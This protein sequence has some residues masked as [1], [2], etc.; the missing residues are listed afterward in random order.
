M[1]IIIITIVV[2][3]SHFYI[4]RFAKQLHMYLI[5]SFEY[6][7]SRILSFKEKNNGFGPICMK[8][9]RMKLG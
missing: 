3:N 9:S 4:C 8:I 1:I 2:N 5:F 6:F 7:K